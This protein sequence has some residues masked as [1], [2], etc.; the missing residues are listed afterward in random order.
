MVP[1][2]YQMFY[3][4]VYFVGMKS[5][6]NMNAFSVYFS[7]LCSF[8]FK[9]KL[10]VDWL[11]PTLFVSLSYLYNTLQRLITENSRQIFPEQELCGLI[12]NFHIHV[13]VSDLYIPMIG[14]PILLQEK[15][16]TDP[17]NI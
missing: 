9:E 8:L 10:K 12:P 2:E 16:W 1:Q 11:Y 6:T 7:V 5:T 15:I 13:S 14:L 3:K 17:G 4:K